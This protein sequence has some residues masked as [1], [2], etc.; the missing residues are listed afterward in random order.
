MFIIIYK[1]P[2]VVE[3]AGWRICG[4]I[5]D[6]T[7]FSLTTQRISLVLHFLVCKYN[8]VYTSYSAFAPSDLLAA[9]GIMYCNHRLNLLSF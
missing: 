6:Q 3:K 2:V 9:P 8:I 4:C 7:R 5:S 1:L